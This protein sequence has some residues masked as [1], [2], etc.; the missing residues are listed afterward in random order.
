M[1]RPK[2]VNVGQI[3]SLGYDPLKDG[4][5]DS[6]MRSEL[7]PLQRKEYVMAKWIRFLGLAGLAVVLVAAWGYSR[8]ATYVSLK[9]SFVPGAA[10]EILNDSEP[11]AGEYAYVDAGKLQASPWIKLEADGHLRMAIARSDLNGRYVQILLNNVVQPPVYPSGTNCALYWGIPT[12]PALIEYFWFTSGAEV[13]DND[14]DGIMDAFYPTLNFLSMSEGDLKYCTLTS[15]IET[16][17]NECEY[18]WGIAPTAETADDIVKVTVIN[19]YGAKVWVITPY[20]GRQDDIVVQDCSKR[21]LWRA[22]YTKR[23]GAGYGGRCDA[24]VWEAD[25]VLKLTLK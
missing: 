7:E 15:R 16:F 21:K 9:A 14:Q 25:F 13:R 5:L 3:E 1:E 23:S 4:R 8:G 2:W 19:E 11:P 12:L 17:D 6:I 18:D 22:I 10:N 20:V 24:G